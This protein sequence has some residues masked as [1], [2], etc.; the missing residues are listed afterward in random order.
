MIYSYISLFIVEEGQDRNSNEVGNL[1]AGA[2][3]K[4][5]EGSCFL[6]CSLWVAEPAFLENP[7][8]PAHWWTQPQ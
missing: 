5:T 8:L 1:E 4:V 3:T 7:G 6:A 2:D